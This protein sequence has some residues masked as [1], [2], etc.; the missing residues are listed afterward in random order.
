MQ[1]ESLDRPSIASLSIEILLVVFAGTL[2][3]LGSQQILGGSLPAK[4]ASIWIA[5]LLMLLCIYGSLVR[6][7]HSWQ[8]LGLNH[9]QLLPVHKLIGKS[10]VVFLAAMGAFV[11]G[12]IVAAN[13][14]GIPEPA[15]MSKYD[16]LQ[17]NIG[18]TV[19]ALCSVYLVSSFAEEVIYR[20]YLLSRLLE[21]AG[22]SKLGKA[23]ALFTSSA[24]F[25]AVHSDW[26]IAG[27]IQATCMGLALGAAFMLLRR[28]L[29]ILILAHAYMDT[30][31]IVQ[32]YFGGS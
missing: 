27:M 29:W 14:V 22:A 4:I 2:G 20:G 23:F 28:K 18:L 19:L 16:Y 5:N 24:V 26:G 13:L 11:A 3:F 1:D 15:D 32:M 17:G 7:K 10:L 8:D 6:R 31:L 21:V 25:G 30:I 9:Q 12:A